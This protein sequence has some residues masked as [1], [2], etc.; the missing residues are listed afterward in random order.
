MKYLNETVVKDITVFIQ[1]Q[2]EVSSCKY[3]VWI[4]DILLNLHMKRWT[5]PCR[6]KPRPASPNC[7][8][9]KNQKNEHD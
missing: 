5:I 7:H 8:M 3:G 4:C 2:D 6:A 1:M 9:Q